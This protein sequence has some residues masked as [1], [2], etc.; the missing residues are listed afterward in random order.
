MCV[1]PVESMVLAHPSAI[2]HWRVLMGPTKPYIA[3]NTAP[4]T[5]RGSYGLTDTRNSTHGSGQFTLSYKL[6]FSCI[7]YR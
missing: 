2:Q 4:D 3:H 7:T 6:L 1:G 5:I